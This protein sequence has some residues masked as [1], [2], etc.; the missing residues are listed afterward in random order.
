MDNL[1][2]IWSLNPVM[3]LN[4]QITAI[5]YNINRDNNIFSKN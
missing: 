2:V 5:K 1:V 3:G 4:L